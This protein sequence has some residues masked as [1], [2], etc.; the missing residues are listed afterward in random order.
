MLKIRRPL[1]RLIF[2]MGIAIPGKT[3]FLIETA[4]WILSLATPY[5]STYMMKESHG[6]SFHI[7]RPRCRNLLHPTKGQRY[8]YLIFHFMFTQQSTN[9]TMNSPV[10]YDKLS[11]T[12]LQERVHKSLSIKTSRGGN[13]PTYYITYKNIPY[14]LTNKNC[15]VSSRGSMRI[16]TTEPLWHLCMSRLDCYTVSSW[17]Q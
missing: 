5:L 8:K 6:G 9:Q 3:V 17:W 16:M 13:Y 2:N 1:G 14:L 12:Q 7:T 11:L 4:P 10:K 15:W